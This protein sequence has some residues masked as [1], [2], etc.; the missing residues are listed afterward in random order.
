MFQGQ[1]IGFWELIA[2]SYQEKKATTA[3]VI[4]TKKMVSHRKELFSIGHTS[5]YPDFKIKISKG[6]SNILKKYIVSGHNFLVQEA[7]PGP[8]WV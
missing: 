3:V 8:C 6:I 2:P 1:K 4:A 5:L 7:L